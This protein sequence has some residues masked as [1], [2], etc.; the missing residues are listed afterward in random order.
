[1]ILSF[2]A[3]LIH[4]NSLD[5]KSISAIFESKLLSTTST[6]DIVRYDV[7]ARCNWSL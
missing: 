6:A 4:L 7:M 5:D 1:M 2:P 3:K